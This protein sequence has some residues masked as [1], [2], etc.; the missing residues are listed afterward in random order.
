MDVPAAKIKDEL[1]ILEIA[2]QRTKDREEFKKKLIEAC[3][4]INT[5]YNNFDI[6]G[7]KAKINKAKT[8]LSDFEEFY[9]IFHV[10]LCEA[11]SLI[12]SK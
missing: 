8:Y 11:T 12:R 2:K 6:H 4:H 5:K 3:E 9:Y 10:E 1:E 7:W